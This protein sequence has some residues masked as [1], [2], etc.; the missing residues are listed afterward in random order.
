MLLGFSLNAQWS[1]CNCD[2]PKRNRKTYNGAWWNR[3]E[4]VWWSI[5]GSWM[6]KLETCFLHH[7]DSSQCFSSRR[8][9]DNLYLTMPLQHNDI[10]LSVF[11]PTLKS[12]TSCQQSQIQFQMKIPFKIKNQHHLKI[13]GTE[14][15]ISE[16]HNIHLTSKA[17][18]K[19]HFNWHSPIEVGRELGGSIMTHTSGESQADCHPKK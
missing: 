17:L 9:E 18:G 12:S 1:F 3:R 8:G 4:D 10:K 14:N 19:L 15:G 2:F 13:S 5:D 11:S 6:H 16:A 7:L